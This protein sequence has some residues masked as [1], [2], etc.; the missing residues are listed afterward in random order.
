VPWLES[1][2]RPGTRRRVER[3]ARIVHGTV[4]KPPGLQRLAD[5]LQPVGPQD[6]IIATFHKAKG[7]GPP[8][9][10]PLSA[11]ATAEDD[12]SL[13]SHRA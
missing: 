2:R 12:R 11:L 9:G 1:S 3:E 8:P 7:R 6:P 5:T 4:I 10:E 13:R